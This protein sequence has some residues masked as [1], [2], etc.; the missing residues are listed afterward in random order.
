MALSR[1]AADWSRPP[2]VRVTLT[3]EATRNRLDEETLAELTAVLDEAEAAPGVQVLVLGAVGDAFC[4]GWAL[5]SLESAWRERIAAVGELLTRLRT[6]PLI[7][8]AYVDGAALGG[9]VGLAAACDQV[10]VSERASFRMTEV[11]L[12]LVPAAILPVVARRVGGHRAYGWAL[13]AREL[14]GAQAVEA[15]LA[16]RQGGRD[17]LRRVLI[18]LRA[19]DPAALVALK[20][21]HAELA[22]APAR[23]EERVAE[24]LG[25]R[26]ADPRTHRR[27]ADFREQGL[28]A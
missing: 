27:L 22:P 4:A 28:I 21:Y 5:D 15:G 16:D 26:L 24:V 12:G 18:A 2:V 6:S 14:S 11:L 9:G 23:Y 25:P 20:R 17:G 19:A 3:G 8:I 10:V 13:T 1:T 7:T